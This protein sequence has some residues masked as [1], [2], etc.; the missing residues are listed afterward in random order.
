MLLYQINPVPV[1]LVTPIQLARMVNVFS[2][3]NRTLVYTR[4]NVDSEDG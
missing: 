1:I 4:N 3:A 2:P